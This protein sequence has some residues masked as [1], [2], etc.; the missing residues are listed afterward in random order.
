MAVSRQQTKKFRRWFGVG[1]VI[2]FALFLLVLLSEA[3]LVGEGNNQ[4]L[5]AWASFLA[6]CITLIGFLVTTVI[7]WR[8]ERRE[9]EHSSV[10]LDKNKLELEKLRQD[11][12][13]KL[14]RATSE[15]QGKR[16]LRK[17]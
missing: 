7:T 9:P 15:R 17:R 14:R 12:L 2:S 1:F 4:I 11:T 13:D 16:K 8:K 3:I 5:L 10:D 6:S